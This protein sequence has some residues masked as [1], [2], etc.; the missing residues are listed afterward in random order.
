MA[1]VVTP[2]VFETKQNVLNKVP[3]YEHVTEEMAL[4]EGKAT[5][6]TA[7]K[8]RKAEPKK[9]KGCKTK[10]PPAQ[11]LQD[12]SNAPKVAEETVVRRCGCRH[13]DLSAIKSVGK[14]EAN[15]YIRPNKLLEGRSCLDCKLAVTNMEW[16]L[17]GVKDPCFFVR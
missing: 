3:I 1:G 11:I 2:S 9:S 16:T 7:S 4:D 12:I 10:Q 15:Y 13:G 8:K 17:L 14:A 6:V 5:A